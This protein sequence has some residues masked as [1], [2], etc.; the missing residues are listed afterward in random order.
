[1][2]WF[3]KLLAMYVWLQ[4]LTL[5]TTLSSVTTRGNV[6][7]GIFKRKIA[8]P[9]ICHFGKI[10]SLCG[11]CANWVNVKGFFWQIFQLS[12]IYEGQVFMSAKKTSKI[13]LDGNF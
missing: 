8:V 7:K 3:L 11:G 10:C 4:K 6:R 2:T 12:F 9:F 13:Y 1:M 5:T